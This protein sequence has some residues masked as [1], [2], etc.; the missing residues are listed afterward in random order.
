MKPNRRAFL[1]GTGS[2]IIG[3]PLT[4]FALELGSSGKLFAQ[5]SAVKNARLVTMYFPNGAMP[6]IWNYEN[7]LLPLADMKSKII[8]LQNV[9]NPVTQPTQ[10]AHEQGAAALFT[11]SKLDGQAEGKHQKATSISI[12]QYLSRRI[13]MT[14]SLKKPL[15][16]GVARG[17]AGGHWRSPTWYRRSWMENGDPVSPLIKPLEIFK[18]IFGDQ[19]SVEMKKLKLERQKSVLDTIVEQMKSFTGDASKLPAS[20]KDLLLAHLERVRDLEKRVIEQHN[21]AAQ[22]CKVPSGMPPTINFGGDDL[23]PYS[24][25]DRV[26]RLQMD[27]MTLALQCG[28]THTGSL[29]FCSAGEDYVNP[30]ISNETDHGTSHWSNEKSKRVYLEYRRYHAANLRYFM[31]KLNAAGILDQTAI[32]YASEF[33]DGRSH[34]VNPQPHLIAGGGGNL[35]MG[36]IIDASK[37]KHTLNDIY[38]TLLTSLGQKTEKFGIEKYNISQITE[39]NKV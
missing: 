19:S 36:Q 21:D 16:L 37:G 7:A 23:L 34:V 25:F 10:D 32:V 27:L 39:M 1:K 29:M 35:K 38:S 9:S 11:G 20:H 15:V 17:W 22:M 5:D 28:T 24:E 8:L 12:D 3:L 14:T 2:L 4:E 26:Y 6:E 18:T 31:D 13:D 33:G 30:M